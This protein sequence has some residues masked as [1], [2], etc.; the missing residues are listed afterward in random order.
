MISRMLV[1][2]AG[3]LDCTYEVVVQRCGCLIITGCD[4]CSSA[5]GMKGQ[6][7]CLL[8][9]GVVYGS[10]KQPVSRDES[11]SSSIPGV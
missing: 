3:M 8:V 6:R 11:Q 4:R 2:D 10:A 7:E 1:V 9:D 5:R